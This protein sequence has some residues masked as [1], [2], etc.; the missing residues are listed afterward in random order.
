MSTHVPDS[1]SVC[2]HTVCVDPFHSRRG[3]ALGLLKEYIT[4][5]EA[6]TEIERILLICHDELRGLYEKAG[7]EWLGPSN[8]VH[9]ARP[10]FDMRKTLRESQQIPPGVLEALLA[11]PKGGRPPHRILASFSNAKEDLVSEGANKYT[12]VCI[13]KGCGSVILL[14]KA[15]QFR[16]ELSVQVCDRHSWRMLFDPF[17]SWNPQLTRPLIRFHLFHQRKR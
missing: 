10:W 8:V 12:L 2:I 13:G 1:A 4:R 11:K 7:F 15:A 3:I 5:L 14:P 6:R 17:H 9:G 16:S